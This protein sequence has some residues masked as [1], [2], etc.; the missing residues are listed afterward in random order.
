[1]FQI[2]RDEYRHAAT[3]F[4]G[5]L[6]LPF[7]FECSKAQLDA[8]RIYAGH[9]MS[10]VARIVIGVLFV[11]PLKQRPLLGSRAANNATVSAAGD[12]TFGHELSLGDFVAVDVALCCGSAGERFAQRAADAP[13]V[14]Q[15]DP[16]IAVA[17]DGEL[18][19]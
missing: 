12:V 6:D 8:D 18:A 19:H 7:R 11:D 1:M 17:R 5:A 15:N 14:F 4:T 3:H 10:G 13:A 2:R 9:L 16:V